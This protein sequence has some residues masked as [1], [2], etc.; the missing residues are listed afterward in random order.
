MHQV[1]VLEGSSGQPIYE[2]EPNDDFKIADTLLNER[3]TFGQF[4]RYS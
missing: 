3:V 1:Q 2:S 4:D